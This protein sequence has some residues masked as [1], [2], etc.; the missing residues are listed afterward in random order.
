MI[1]KELIDRH[2]LILDAGILSDRGIRKAVE[3]GKI[4]TDI[5]LDDEQFQPNSLDLRLKSIDIH[6][7]TNY[8]MPDGTFIPMYSPLSTKYHHLKKDEPVEIPHFLSNTIHFAEK[9]KTNYGLRVDLRSGRA[10]RGLI[11][12]EDVVYIDDEG[13]AWIETNNQGKNKIKLY[14]MDKIAHAFFYTSKEEG[15]GY[16]VS[17]KKELEEIANSLSSKLEIDP[18]YLVFNAGN[19]ALIQKEVG[20]DDTRAEQ[21]IFYKKK[22]SD[23]TISTERHL[24]IQLSPEITVPNNVAVHLLPTI[25]YKQSIYKD[26]MALYLLTHSKVIKGGWIESGYKGHATAHLTV[27]NNYFH[28]KKNEPLVY[29][30]AYKYHEDVLRPYGSP[31]LNSHYQNSIGDSIKS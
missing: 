21:N 2:P 19:F 22:L 16:I 12:Y 10:R 13:N 11:N 3:S 18:P 25:P 1:N 14:G 20:I 28:I 5:P 8:R 30:L 15:D 27:F 26:Q 23:T 6:H 7:L 24:V 29:A 31:S 4:I 9:L 17:D